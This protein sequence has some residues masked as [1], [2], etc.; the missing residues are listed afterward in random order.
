M[1]TF[2][3]HF[4]IIPAD[5]VDHNVEHSDLEEPIVLMQPALPVEPTQGIQIDIQTHN[6]LELTDIACLN[7]NS[8]NYHSVMCCLYLKPFLHR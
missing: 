8:F 3:S 1:N 4:D 7:Y 6:L 5:L 2:S